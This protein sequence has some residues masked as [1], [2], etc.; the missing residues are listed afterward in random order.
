VIDA[1]VPVPTD[2]VDAFAVMNAVGLVAFGVVG[3][4]VGDGRR[5][6]AVRRRHPRRPDRGRR[7]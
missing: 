6:L 2:A 5:P 1:A 4:L 7:R 3:A